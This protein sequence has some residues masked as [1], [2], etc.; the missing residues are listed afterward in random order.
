MIPV[1]RPALPNA[2]AIQRYLL[3]IDESR[4]YT[5]LGPLV[6]EF[7]DR[8]AHHFG[9]AQGCVAVVANATLG[10]TLSLQANQ[11]QGRL[12]ILPSW[13]FCASAHAAVAAGLRPYFVDV[14][15]ATWQLTPQDVLRLPE[16]VL[17]DAAAIMPVSAFGALVD[18]DSWDIL[19]SK[20]SIPVV[21]DAAAAFDS[22]K[23]GSSLSV[24][25]L[26]ATK[27][28][29]VGEGGCIVSRD[30]D[31]VD[32]VRMRSNFGFRD[33]RVS[34]WPALNAK[35]TEM[36][37]A[38]GLA[39]LDDWPETQQTWLT[40]LTWYRD[41]LLIGSAGWFE[42]AHW[43]RH[44]SSTMVLALPDADQAA[45]RLAQAGVDTRKWWGTGCHTQPAFADYSTA[46]LGVT[47]KLGEANLGLRRLTSRKETSSESVT[48]SALPSMAFLARRPLRSYLQAT[49][50]R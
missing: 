45:L 37:A 19:A 8:L 48:L 31:L 16:E 27:A 26:H 14:D 11:R 30:R 36:S 49:H 35:M 28:L 29:G 47:S 23:P 6:R 3:R 22:L 41:A 15:P 12:C 21:L 42:A 10:L 25:S 33:A 34:I 46:D 7:E 4:I 38:V 5:N 2:R 39:A 50:D 32:E 44:A 17:A 20:L 13:T 43:P 9:L 1:A 18:I 24:V 40:R